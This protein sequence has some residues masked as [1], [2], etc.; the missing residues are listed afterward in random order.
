VTHELQSPVSAIENYLKL[1]LDGYISPEEQPEILEK[2]MLRTQE[3]RALIADLLELG[4]L[5][6]I[7]T[8]KTEEVHL[9]EILR[10]VVATC[11]EQIDRKNLQ[12]E[13]QI[14]TDIPAIIAA[15]EQ[16]K[17]LWN[18]LISN[19]IKYTPENGSIDIHLG[20]EQQNI[21]G[22]V[23]DTGIGI[24]LE[25]QAQLFSE[26]FRA[27]NAKDLEVPGTGLGLAI[28]KR[29]IDGLKGTIEV[30]SQAGQG[31]VFTFRIPVGFD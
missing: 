7:E 20:V 4:H 28:V 12:L 31:S 21:V 19:A 26:F 6:V 29:I 30:A 11:Q 10:A 15:P 17:S 16:I 2:C 25:D 18:N 3:E 13:I 14:A 5:E 9:D 23:R 22:L 27:S 24:P 1:I 8:F